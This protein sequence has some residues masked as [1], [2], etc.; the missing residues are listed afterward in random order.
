MKV[1]LFLAAVY[2]LIFNQTQHKKKHVPSPGVNFNNY[3]RA[4]AKDTLGKA[5]STPAVY[6]ANYLNAQ[7]S[8]IINAAVR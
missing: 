3:T 5:G 6:F 1:V 8:A 4:I 2:A 7:P